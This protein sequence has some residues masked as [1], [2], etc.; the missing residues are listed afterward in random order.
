MPI[1]KI[2]VEIIHWS[3]NMCAVQS[4]LHLLNRSLITEMLV[5]YFWDTKIWWKN[6]EL[7]GMMKYQTLRSS[8][9]F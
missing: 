8:F 4:V 1:F 6:Q 9:S 2:L 3:G 7:I 5:K